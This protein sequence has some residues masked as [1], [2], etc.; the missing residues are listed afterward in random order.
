MPDDLC[1]T[2]PVSWA[3]GF[4]GE[5]DEQVDM[6]YTRLIAF[7]TRHSRARS[8]TPSTIAAFCHSLVGTLVAHRYKGVVT[9]YFYYYY[10]IDQTNID[11]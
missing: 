6:V 1:R 11:R 5:G 4:G 10:E 9:N 7:T 2:T 3:A 8:T